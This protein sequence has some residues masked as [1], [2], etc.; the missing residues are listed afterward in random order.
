MLADRLTE[1]SSNRDIAITSRGGQAVV[2]DL[3]R[4]GRFGEIDQDPYL[5]PGDLVTVAKAPR[6]VS[7]GGEI[8]RAGTYQLRSGETLDELVNFYADGFSLMADQETI[9]INRQTGTEDIAEVIEI[10]LDVVEPESVSLLDLDEVLVSS[11]LARLPVIYVEGAVR[12]AGKI[13]HR[14]REGDTLYTVM[15]S[16]RGSIDPG[17][18]LAQ[19]VITNPATSEQRMVDVEYLLYSGDRSTDVELSPEDRIVIPIGDFQVFLT[20]E[21]R[22]SV[23]ITATQYTRLSSLLSDRLTGYSSNRDITI[24]SNSGDVSV[25]DLFRAGRFGEIDQNPYL[26][27]GELLVVG[28]S[29]DLGP[30]KSK[31][32]KHWRN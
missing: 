31:P 25:Y 8:K 16:I 10:N 26:R 7:I 18:N 6:R 32:G 1:Y 3:F 12:P 20:G 15:S 11:T 30:I 24:T 17:V 29:S 23:W 27:P 19:C 21:V 2:Y 28:K 14:L 22:N 5:K 9:F 13:R 4:A